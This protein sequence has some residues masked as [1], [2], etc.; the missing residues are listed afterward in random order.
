MD[1]KT[2]IISRTQEINDQLITMRRDLHRLA[3]LSG[4]EYK[5]H[6]YIAGVLESHHIAFES[7][8]GTG[9][10]GI[11]KTGRPGKTLALRADMDALLIP[12][13]P[14]NLKRERL[15]TSDDPEVFH[16]C[17]HDG[18]MAMLLATSIILKEMEPE[19]NGTFYLCFEEGEEIGCGIDAMIDALND[20]GIDAV[21]GIHLLNS[22]PVN[23]ISVDPGPRLAGLA[24]IDFT[25]H[26]QGGH[27]SRPDLSINPVFTAA[28]ILNNLSNTFANQID[29]NETVTLG[30]TSIEAKSAFNV[31]PNDA[32]IQGSYRFFNIK[33]G[34]KAIEL[35]KSVCEHSAAMSKATI[36]Y[37][38]D[39]GIHLYPTINDPSLSALA[40]KALTDQF[41]SEAVVSCEPWYASESFHR[42]LDLYPGVFA[43]VGIQN[44]DDG[45][46][47]QHHNEYFDLDEQALSMGVIASLRYALSFQE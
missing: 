46:G 25:I 39:F 40:Q 19:L 2:E 13:Q 24:K 37:A 23:T 18:H 28:M 26:G 6:D 17:G 35:T 29:A 27:G 12:E 8:K 22:L 43:F 9:I 15:V 38:D 11:I 1:I 10:L 4:K 21:W 20:K 45:I 33:E 42:Y 44:L 41:G 36:E 32:R 5:T 7:I 34:M 31:I 16:A 47:A 3:E 14:R 30:I